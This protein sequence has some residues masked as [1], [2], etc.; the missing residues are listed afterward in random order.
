VLG[1]LPQMNVSAN[2]QLIGTHAAEF[3]NAREDAAAGFRDF[4]VAD[5]GDSFFVLGGAALG[6]NKVRMRIDEP[7]ENDASAE[8][9][10]LGATRLAKAFDVFARSHGVNFALANQ[11]RAVADDFEIT[12]FAAASRSGPAQGEK[13][14]A[15]SDEQVG[16]DAGDEFSVLAR[17][18]PLR[19][20][21]SWSEGEC[22]LLFRAGSV[23][24]L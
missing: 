23:R 16:H 19:S 8:I 21:V 18:L 3:A 5:A 22:G 4:F 1:H 14:R 9:E 6:K 20:A 24:V 13:L 15:A 2:F 12:Q 10:F 17:E 11:E 7:G